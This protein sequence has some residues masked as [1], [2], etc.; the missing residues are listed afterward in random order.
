MYELWYLG[1]VG[2]ISMPNSVTVFPGFLGLGNPRTN[3]QV[4]VM[5]VGTCVWLQSRGAALHCWLCRLDPQQEGLV[6]VR[7]VYCP[8]LPQQSVWMGLG[9]IPERERE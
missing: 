2:G 7:L 5:A 8:G 3:F 9:P 4:S 6:S 1:V